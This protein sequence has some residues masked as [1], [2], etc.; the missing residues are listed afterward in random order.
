M[1]RINLLGVSKAKRR[2]GG[3]VPAAIKAPNVAMIAG[4][5]AVVT[6][7]GNYGWYLAL[8]H[9]AS[10]IH[11][12]MQRAEE[13]N[14]RLAS[15]KSKYTELEKQ[16]NEYEH[17]VNVINELAKE[18]QGPA[19]LLTTIAATVNRTD[20]VWLNSMKEDGNAIDLQGMALSVDAVATLMQNLR[21]TGHFR[22]VE[23]KE[24]YQDDKV[25][26]VQALAFTL[27]CERQQQESQPAQQAQ[28]TKKS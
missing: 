12:Q 13:T 1:I 20:A 18:K 6:L 24:T 28:Q 14:R 27:T 5:L 19:D 23:I 3:A 8:N 4:L 22:S 25:K 21:S 2:S 9:D 26:E 10:Q 15:V 16:K 11:V 17:R 7:G